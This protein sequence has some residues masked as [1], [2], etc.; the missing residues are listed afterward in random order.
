MIQR[1]A[2]KLKSNQGNRLN[3]IV[4]SG[5]PTRLAT[6]HQQLFCERKREGRPLSITEG[7]LPALFMK[8]TLQGV[9][10]GSKRCTVSRADRL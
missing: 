7:K 8:R 1:I 3:S 4:T 6:I 2:R 9:K 10:D 5:L